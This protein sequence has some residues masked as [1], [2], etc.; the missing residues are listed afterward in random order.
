MPAQP[1]PFPRILLGPGP[2]SVSPR[3]LEVMGRAPIGYLDP[4][5]FEALADLQE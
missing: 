5:L 1:L 3:V 2:S 4:E